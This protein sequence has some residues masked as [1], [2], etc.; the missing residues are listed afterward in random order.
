MR[1][2]CYKVCRL[3]RLQISV[4]EAM[5]AAADIAANECYLY[6]LTDPNKGVLH[7]DG[8]VR[9]FIVRVKLQIMFTENHIPWVVRYLASAMLMSGLH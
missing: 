8:S 6:I 1:G 4:L 7:M 2:M 3:T 5:T 9:E